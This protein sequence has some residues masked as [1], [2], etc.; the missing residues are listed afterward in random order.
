[1]KY[2]KNVA[3]SY[4]ST[5]YSIPPCTTTNMSVISRRP[6]LAWQGK[7]VCAHTYQY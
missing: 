7:E 2:F 1:M 6:K 5:T 4:D 3:G